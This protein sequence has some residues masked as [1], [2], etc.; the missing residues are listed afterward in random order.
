MPFSD[1]HRDDHRGD[2]PPPPARFPIQDRYDGLRSSPPWHRVD[3]SPAPPV[4]PG[5]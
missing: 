2:R 1:Q 5:R 4:P 3:E